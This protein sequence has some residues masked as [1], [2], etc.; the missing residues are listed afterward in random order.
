MIGDV[1]GPVVSAS[2]KRDGQLEEI[3]KW[4]SLLAAIIN[5]PNFEMTL[6]TVF[7]SAVDPPGLGELIDFP[8]AN[9]Q[10]RILPGIEI[11][12]EEQ[13]HRG[14]SITAKSWDSLTVNNGAGNASSHNHTT[15]L[16]TP[17]I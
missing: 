15:Q 4:G 3:T 10:G 12:W 1:Y 6:N 13:G 9:I 7:L 5:N 11:S 16:L 14:L 2:V 8:L 17:I